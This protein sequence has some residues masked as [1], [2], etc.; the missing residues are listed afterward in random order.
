MRILDESMVCKCG[1]TGT[2]GECEPDVDRDGSLGCPVCLAVV[3]E[4]EQV[5]FE[6]WLANRRPENFKKEWR[7]RLLDALLSEVD[8]HMVPIDRLSDTYHFLYFMLNKELSR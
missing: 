8:A 3:Q 5:E 1:W 2:V 6:K 7:R 4:V